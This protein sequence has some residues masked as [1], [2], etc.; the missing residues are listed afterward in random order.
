MSVKVNTASHG[1]DDTLWLF[2]D[3][4]LHEMSELALHNLCQLQFQGLDGTDCGSSG[5]RGHGVGIVTTESMNVHL[6]VANVGDVVVLEIQDALC[7]FNDSG[8]VRGDEELD[9][10][11]KAIFGH[12]STGLGAGDL[13]RCCGSPGH[14]KERGR[15]SSTRRN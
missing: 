13:L 4:L 3:L 2:V 1:V 7:M 11:G 8:G 6:S 10:L 12:E 9:W 14:R 5:A 15:R